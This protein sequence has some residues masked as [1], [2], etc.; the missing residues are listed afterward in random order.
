MRF[1]VGGLDVANGHGRR[2]VLSDLPPKFCGSCWTATPTGAPPR[3]SSS[4]CS[5]RITTKGNVA[6]VIR[7]AAPACRTSPCPARHHHQW[8]PRPAVTLD[9]PS[10][11]MTRTFFAPRDVR[12]SG[13]RF[14]PMPTPKR[15]GNRHRPRKARPNVAG[16]HSP[17]W[18]TG[19]RGQGPEG[20]PGA[21]RKLHELLLS[22]HDAC[23][24]I[25]KERKL[26]RTSASAS[27]R[28]QT[29]PVHDY[30]GGPLSWI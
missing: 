25:L 23:R 3:T 2:P 21:D 30:R 18:S 16:S 9:I 24:H 19:A 26:S 12:M 8:A 5:G 14:P 6:T 4:R 10:D 17:T 13:P 7:Y 11:E 28:Q 20:Q 27:C 22:G 29:G 1:G 15:L